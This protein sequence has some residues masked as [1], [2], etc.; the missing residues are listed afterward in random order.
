MSSH[1]PRRRVFSSITLPSFL[2]GPSTKKQSAR[3]CPRHKQCFLALTWHIKDPRP[4][5]CLWASTSGDRATSTP[6]NMRLR[7]YSTSPSLLSAPSELLRSSCLFPFSSFHLYQDY[8]LKPFPPQNHHLDPSSDVPTF[9][10]RKNPG[11]PQ[12]ALKSEM[13]RSWSKRANM[14]VFKHQSEASQQRNNPNP[15]VAENPTIFHPFAL[16]PEIMFYFRHT[17]F[18]NLFFFCVSA[19]RLF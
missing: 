9:D 13:R 15:L 12:V 1:P 5:R 10:L 4:S 18:P 8:F 7:F 17:L 6:E 3:K 14:Q 11:K 19:W 16:H 2:L